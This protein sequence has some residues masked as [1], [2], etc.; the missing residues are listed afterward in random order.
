MRKLAYLRLFWQC[1]ADKKAPWLY[2][3]FPEKDLLSIVCL[4]FLTAFS[5]RIIGKGCHCPV[6][7]FFLFFLF[8]N[9]QIKVPWQWCVCV[10]VLCL[11]AQLC[12]FERRQDCLTV[13]PLLTEIS[14]VRQD[15]HVSRYNETFI[16]HEILASQSSSVTTAR[17]FYDYYNNHK[18]DLLL[19][20]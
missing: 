6:N 1:K 13:W 20:K 12:V 11:C 15:Q 4:L 19:G 3:I 8:K 18:N 9:A 10:F 16:K 2:C 17:E 14:S 7:S 5:W